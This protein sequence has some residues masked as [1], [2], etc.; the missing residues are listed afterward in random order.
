MNGR[1]I[2]VAITVPELQT[3]L[4]SPSRIVDPVPPAPVKHRNNQIHVYDALGVYF[5][6]NHQTRHI[7]G[8][9]VVFWPAEQ[10][11]AFTPRDRFSGELDVAGYRMP[12]NPSL[13]T[14]VER[15]QSIR[16]KQYVAGIF[17]Q[18]QCDYSMFVTARGKRLASGRRSRTL[19]LVDISLSWRHD[20]W[21]KAVTSE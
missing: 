7:D 14:F 5:H 16:L 11:F 3:L 8:C 21:S 12:G 20:P 1:E 13:N 19:F 10:G 6:E 9:T 4:G 18:K 17:G 2:D 15:C